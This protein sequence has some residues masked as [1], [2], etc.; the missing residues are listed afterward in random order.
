MD[1]RPAVAE[2]LARQH[3]RILARWRREVRALPAARGLD[4][5]ALRDQVPDLLHELAR[6]V[7]AADTDTL[8]G[9]DP[10]SQLAAAHGIERL[11]AGFDVEE[12]VA[13]YNLLRRSIFTEAAEQ[14][15]K[16]TGRTAN[17][18]NRVLDLAIAESL[19]NFVRQKSIAE[20]ERV[21]EYL[22][23]V[24]HDMKSPLGALTAGLDLVRARAGKDTDLVTVCRTMGHSL[25][26]INKLVQR[27]L[28]ESRRMS[29]DI[30]HN[31]DPEP[32]PLEP[33]IAAVLTAMRGPAAARGV[34]LHQQIPRDAIVHA[35]PNLLDTIFSNL[36]H[37]AIEHAGASRIEIGAEQSGDM[38]RCR[39]EDDGRGIPEDN[40]SA[41]FD[42]YAT[43]NAER[44][45][46]GLGLYMARRYV[47]A[48]G[49]SIDVEP[50]SG[51]GSRFVFT[52]HRGEPVPL[53]GE[54]D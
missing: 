48:H 38:W 5:P 34:V 21:T 11:R 6:H 36:V 10:P 12:V 47:E 9:N 31:L 42:P 16:L 15:V 2:M 54:G 13:E 51:G 18:V 46:T 37:N 1:S 22:A 3:G 49:G 24:V 33:V 43:G 32:L 35:D 30:E 45:G 29:E 14:G 25:E 50:R 8:S 19:S 17:M 7:A 52:L 23:F 20:R 28:D 27:L 44:G 4:A 26:Q 39:V 40:R 53:P 41:V